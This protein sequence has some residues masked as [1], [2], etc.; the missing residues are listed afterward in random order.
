MDKVFILINSVNRDWLIAIFTSI[1]TGT[2]SIVG[3]YLTIKN[4]NKIIRSQLKEQRSNAN[5]ER[6]LQVYPFLSYTL[7]DTTANSHFD[8]EYGGRDIYPFGRALK[9]QEKNSYIVDNK[10][11]YITKK[12]LN[13]INVGQNLCISLKVVDIKLKGTQP[14]EI[15]SWKFPF[16]VLIL[17]KNSKVEM[18]LESGIPK[19]LHE[20]SKYSNVNDI[21]QS[22]TVILKLSYSDILDNY[23]EQSIEVSIYPTPII[24]TKGGLDFFLNMNISKIHKPEYLKDKSIF[25]EKSDSIEF[26]IDFF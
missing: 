5:E 7:K 21:P 24:Y 1:M 13:I 8:F 14:A 22:Y 18:Y 10:N 6:R 12:S 20:E 4:E 26:K 3:I 11:N 2:I 9:E 19:K 16:E 17:E 25:D 15:R 23:Y